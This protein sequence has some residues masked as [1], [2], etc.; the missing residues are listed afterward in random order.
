MGRLSYGAHRVEFDVAAAGDE[1]EHDDLRSNLGFVFPA[2]LVP[3][4]AWS[5]NPEPSHVRLLLGPR[6]RGGDEIESSL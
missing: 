5:G 3:A 4:K 2:K 1:I 6:F